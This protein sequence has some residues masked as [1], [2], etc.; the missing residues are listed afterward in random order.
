MIYR[1][2]ETVRMSSGFI[3]YKIQIR[4]W[5]GWITFK[6]FRTRKERDEYFYKLTN[7]TT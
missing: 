5:Y 3:S 1:T 7:E 2:A 4:R 6:L